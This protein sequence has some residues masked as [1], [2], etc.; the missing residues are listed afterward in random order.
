MASVHCLF[1]KSARARL[2]RAGSIEETEL[3]E[4]ETSR[5]PSTTRIS[6]RVIRTHTQMCPGCSGTAFDETAVLELE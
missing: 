2:D 6:S 4:Y 1:F 5:S 3:P